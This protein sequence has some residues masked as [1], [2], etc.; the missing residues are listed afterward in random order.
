MNDD[1]SRRL[2]MTEDEKR[3]A[4]VGAVVLLI[5]LILGL[6]YVLG[7]LILKATFLPYGIPLV[8]AGL[9][10]AIGA[11]ALWVMGTEGGE[12]TAQLCKDTYLLAFTQLYR[13]F[14]EEE[15]EEIEQISQQREVEEDPIKKTQGVIRRLKSRHEEGLEQQA[16]LD[17]FIEDCERQFEH[18]AQKAR[19]EQE[20]AL[21]SSEDGDERQARKYVQMAAINQRHADGFAA[22]VQTMRGFKENLVKMTD[23]LELDIVQIEGQLA[24]QT[25]SLRGV[26]LQESAAEIHFGTDGMGSGMDAEMQMA[27][28]ELSTAAELREAEIETRMSEAARTL[29]GVNISN[30]SGSKRAIEE[31]ATTFSDLGSLNLGGQKPPT[32][33]VPQVEESKENESDRRSRIRQALRQ[34]Q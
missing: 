13:Y 24:L 11:P 8:M 10:T 22:F 20:S 26:D 14:F 3:A 15:E 17:H 5:P 16:T 6:L 19:R 1:I 33:H 12:H 29:K 31:L 34:N 28:V 9:L 2:R 21:Q 25:A 32:V 7:P 4:K 27:L 23:Q 30:M 18:F